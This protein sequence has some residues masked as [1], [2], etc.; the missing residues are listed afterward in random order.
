MHLS[1][2]DIMTNMTIAKQ[3]LGKHRLKAG[4]ATQAEVHL[5]GNGSLISTI[6]DKRP[7]HELFC[8][9]GLFGPPEVIKQR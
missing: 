3:R 9:V 7:K 5:L 2:Y 8:V 1:P 6:T 4:I